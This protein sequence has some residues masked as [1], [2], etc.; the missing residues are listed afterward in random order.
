MERVGRLL[1]P[2]GEAAECWALWGAVSSAR[3]LGAQDSPA[4]ALGPAGE[5]GQPG[6]WH[7][8]S[9]DSDFHSFCL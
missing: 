3:V 6:A 2:A 7:A 8:C 9:E 5:S 1:S 4:G